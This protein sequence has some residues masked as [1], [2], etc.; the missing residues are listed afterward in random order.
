MRVALTIYIADKL[1]HRLTIRSGRQ[2]TADPHSYR[3]VIHDH[4]AIYPYRMIF[5]QPQSTRLLEPNWLVLR[6]SRKTAKGTSE[7][8][9][10]L[11]A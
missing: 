11:L 9:Q 5:V 10:S 8:D 6:N 2:K 7:Y 4:L 3:A 1:T